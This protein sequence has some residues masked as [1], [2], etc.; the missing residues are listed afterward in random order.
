MLRV[1]KKIDVISWGAGVHI[2]SGGRERKV[3]R[4]L[5][6]V[7]GHLISEL[8]VSNRII[9]TFLSKILS[10]FY[11]VDG[12][13]SREMPTGILGRRSFIRTARAH[14]FDFSCN[15]RFS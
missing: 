10:L 6:Q 14:D 8:P 1:T 2:T 7:E 3:V 4:E 12:L 11:L 13:D 9:S 15:E 5:C